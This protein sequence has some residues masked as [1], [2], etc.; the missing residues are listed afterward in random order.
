MQNAPGV[1]VNETPEGL[2]AISGV[3]TSNTAFVGVFERGPLNKATRVT[4]FSEFERVFGGVFAPSEASY[5]VWHYFLNG[6][7]VAFIVRV[8][9]GAHAAATVN[10]P[11]TRTDGTGIMTVDAASDGSWGNTLRIGIAHGGAGSTTFDMIVREYQDS[12][13]I[14]EDAFINLSIVKGHTR[15]AA[16]V[17]DAESELITIPHTGSDLPTQTVIDGTPATALDT[18]LKAPADALTPLDGGNDGTLPGNTDAW[19]DAVWATIGGD[20]ATGSGIFALDA[21][22]P[23]MFSLM[24]LPDLSVLNHARMAKAATVYQAAHAYCLRNFAFLIVDIPDGTTC[25]NVHNWTTALGGA[26][27]RNAA[28]YYPKVTGP[29][30]TNPAQPRIMPTSGIAAGIYA[31]T[32]TNHGVWKAPAGTAANITGGRP[33]EI[34]TDHQQGPLNVAGINALRTFP[35]YNSVIWGARTL[36][37]ADAL[38]SEWRYI[39]VRRLALFIENS[40]SRGLQWLVFEPNDEPLWAN[41]RLTVGAF[42]DQL[43]RQGAFHGVSADDAYFVKCDNETTTQADINLGILNIVVGFAPVRPAE[44]VV[45]RVQQRI[46]TAP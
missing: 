11:T 40:L 33:V 32:D 22:T 8:A 14:R 7:S 44:F 13:I 12:K 29:D 19:R 42:M 43:H 6:G 25:A 24:V 37:G 46:Q 23:D 41:V 36:D 20:E 9:A 21:I 34:L 2:H 4:S 45:L 17:I 27:R 3:A 30:P 1:Y 38:A 10:L 28:L 39:S 15:Y 26:V 18:L 16:T 35:A 5:A 31:R